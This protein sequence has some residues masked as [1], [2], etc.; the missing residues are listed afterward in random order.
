MSKELTLEQNLIDK[1]VSIYG[2]G[3]DFDRVSYHH[4]KRSGGMTFNA[5]RTGHASFVIPEYDKGN[6]AGVIA[7]QR[8]RPEI[9]GSRGLAFALGQDLIDNTGTYAFD[10]ALNIYRYPLEWLQNDRDGIVILKPSE[11]SGWLK[12]CP[13]MAC[14]DELQGRRVD[15]WRQPPKPQ[16]RILIPEFKRVAV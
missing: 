15:E 5:D 10:G 8:D 7:W 3:F 9:F 12:Y 16:G 1:L 11:T 13:R 2:G 6:L 14:Q 4:D